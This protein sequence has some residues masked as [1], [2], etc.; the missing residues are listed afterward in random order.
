LTVQRYSAE[1]LAARLGSGFR[2]KS[3]SERHLTPRG[4]AQEFV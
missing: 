1:T 2:L 3:Q 4:A